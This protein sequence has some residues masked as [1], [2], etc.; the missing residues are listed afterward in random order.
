MIATRHEEY[1][2]A[3]GE[4]PFLLY[5]DLARTPFSQSREQNWHDDLEIQLCTDGHGS[6]LLDGE[7]YPFFPNDIVVVNGNV[8]HHTGTDARLLYTCLIINADFC[9]QI[10]IDVHEVLFQPHVKDEDLLLLLMALREAYEQTEHPFRTVRV[11]ALLLQFLCLLSENYG[12]KDDFPTIRA[13]RFARVKQAL[14]Y[15]RTN[16]TKKISLEELAKATYTD[17]YTLCRDFK[18]AVGKTVIGYIN[19]YRCRAAAEKIAAG[20]TVAESARACGFE[21]LSYFTKTFKAVMGNL[22]SECKDS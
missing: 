5:T 13:H 17:K 20:Q 8:L 12:K 16:Y 18:K 1:G 15:I 19:E 22:P 6:V 3:F 9:K 2:K 11:H 10:G 7:K 21:N 14:A 4:I